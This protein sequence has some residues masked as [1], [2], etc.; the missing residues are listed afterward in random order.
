VIRSYVLNV[1]SLESRDVPTVFGTPWPNGEHLTLSFAPDGTLISGTPSNLQQLLSQLGPQSEYDILE[2]FQAWAANANINI[3][4]VSDDG[5]AFGSGKAVQGNPGFGDIRIGG[6]PLP[7]DVIAIT[8]P[9]TIFDDS[10]GDVVVNSSQPFGASGYDL[11]TVLMHEA[12][13]ALGLPD[14]DDP[15]SVMYTYYQG[16]ETTLAPEDIAAIQALYGAPQPDQYQGS[17]GNG[18]LATATPYG[19]GP[20]LAGLSSPGE[21]EDFKFSTGLLT[22]SATIQLNAA[23]LSLLTANLEVLNSRGQEIASTV[24]NDPTNNDLTI[25]LDHVRPGETYYVQVSAAQDNVFGIGSY[26]LSIAQQNLLSGVTGLVNQLIADAGLNSTLATA[27]N[28]VSSL[29]MGGAQS[30]NNVE[31]Y[32]GTSSAQDYYRIAVPA[33]QSNAPV[34]M[35]VTIWG[36]NGATLN[37]WVNAYDAYGNELSTQV[38]TANGNTTILQASGLQPGGVYYINATSD[39]GTTGA[40]ELSADVGTPTVQILLLGSGTLSES[41]PQESGGFTL[42]ETAE[43]HLVLSATGDSGT[44]EMIVTN[45]DGQIVSSMSAAA[46]RARSVDLILA[47]GQY[48]VTVQT[49]DGSTLSFQLGLMVLTDP[50]GA[51][52]SDPTSNP[53]PTSPPPPLSGSYG[54]SSGG[55]TSSQTTTTWENQD[56]TNSGQ[57]Y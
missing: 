13:H 41:V 52:P 20:L 53:Q 25:T 28:L 16:T 45:A 33:S 10:S 36:E 42:T 18:T 11:S 54:D 51:Q 7:S 3:G 30:D 46:D 6:I 15:N 19:N 21:I 43:I 34:N 56:T 2:A 35:L 9:Y 27:T 40:F 49:V 57:N 23:G 39:S 8:T 48:T 37:P 24:T 38:F 12:G 47:A 26:Q 44:V 29:V 22:T 5:T 50:V 17:T 55:D 4:L 32:F 14:N 1:E 31:G